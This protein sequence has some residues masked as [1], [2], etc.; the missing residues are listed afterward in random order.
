MLANKEVILDGKSL[1]ENIAIGARSVKGV[2]RKE[3]V[4]EA[5]RAALMHEFVRGIYHLDTRLSLV[6]VWV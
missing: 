4:E 5:C 6:V 3:D 2:V 1:F